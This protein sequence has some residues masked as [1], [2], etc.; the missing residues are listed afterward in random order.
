MIVSLDVNLRR[1]SSLGAERVALSRFSRVLTM[2]ECD[3]PGDLS[4]SVRPVRKW[5]R[6]A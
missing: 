5:R 6:T 4:D 1:R 2:L 3:P